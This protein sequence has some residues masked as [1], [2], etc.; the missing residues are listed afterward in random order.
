RGRIREPDICTRC[1]PG[2]FFSARA[3]GGGSGRILTC[4]WFPLLTAE[5]RV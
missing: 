4:A 1:L 3:L 5:A 2:R